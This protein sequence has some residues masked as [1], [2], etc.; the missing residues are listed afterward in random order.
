MND[1]IEAYLFRPGDIITH[2]GGPW[3]RCYVDV[4]EGGRYTMIG[5]FEGSAAITLDRAFVE[6][7][8]RLERTTRFPYLARHL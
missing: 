4:C 8:Y 5:E 7:N 2:V 6:A 1:P 3:S